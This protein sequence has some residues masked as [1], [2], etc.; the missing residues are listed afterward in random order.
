[1]PDM[2]DPSDPNDP[3]TGPAGPGPDEGDPTIAVPMGDDSP[4]AEVPVTDPD[5][6]ATAA[7]VGG[8]GTAAAGGDV[9]Q[10][11]GLDDAEGDDSGGGGR[12]GLVIAIIVVAILILATLL[13]LLLTGFFDDDEPSDST[14]TDLF[15]VGSTSLDPDPYLNVDF[16]E[17]VN[18]SDVEALA[19]TGQCR[20]AEPDSDPAENCKV[21][22]TE[23]G[24]YGGTLDTSN[25]RVDEL[26]NVLGQAPT[27]QQEAWAGAVGVS[28]GDIGSYIQGL[29]PVVLLRDTRM[30]THGYTNE[31]AV[32]DEI[33]LQKGAVVL[34][35]NTGEPAVRCAGASPLSGPETES[36]DV[37][38]SGDTWNGFDPSFIWAVDPGSATD[39]FTLQDLSTGEPFFRPAGSSGSSDQPVTTS[40]TTTSSTTTSTTST[41]EPP[42]TTTS[43]TST[44]STTTTTTTT[45]TTV[46]ADAGSAEDDSG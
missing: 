43:T 13:G 28:S 2:S 36:G 17:G 46:A 29:T 27:A 30:T 8:A 7:G 24:L 33:V 41:T 5:A 6:M 26:I 44:T 14:A 40:T 12:R 39:R 22:G 16:S 32:N 4:T 1:M 23:P 11:P 37:Q 3:A 45:T 38:Y 18:R 20:D 10:D 19:P 15:L 21:N 31:L 9:P 25:C 35:E 42:T 34:V